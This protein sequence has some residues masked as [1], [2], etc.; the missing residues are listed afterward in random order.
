MAEPGKYQWEG[1]AYAITGHEVDYLEAVP[2]VA[3][4]W[5]GGIC[6][7][8]RRAGG[9]PIDWSHRTGFEYS[10]DQDIWRL[11]REEYC[12]ETGRTELA[13]PLHLRISP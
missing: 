4:E 7:F 11:A 3:G 5:L 9:M 13:P 2:Y 12:Q 8:V 10:E 6:D 1:T